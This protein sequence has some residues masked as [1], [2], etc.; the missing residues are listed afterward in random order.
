MAGHR[1]LRTP[2]TRAQQ[3]GK[4]LSNSAAMTV[5]L[6]AFSNA[7]LADSANPWADVT[8]VTG[9][10]S[11]DLSVANNNTIT[12]FTDRTVTTASSA[13]IL[14]N[15]SV[16]ILQNNSGS[17]FVLKT[18]GAD[19]DGAQ[20]QGSLKANG[21]VMVLDRNGVFFGTGSRIDVGGIVASTGD[22]DNDA[23]MRGDTTLELSNFGDASVIN[24]GHI[25]IH[26]N[27][28]AALVAPHVVNNGVIEA[29][30]G[31]VSLASGT[32]TATVDMYGDGMVQFAVGGTAGKALIENAGR[33]DGAT[34]QMTAQGAKGV[35]D[36]VI[37]MSGVINATSATVQG[38]KII[39]SGG[40]AGKVKVSGKM[41]ASGAAGGGSVKVT[42][43]T[44]EVT[45]TAE[46][47]ANALTSGNGGDIFF[48]AETDALYRGRFMARGGE[49]S[50]NGGF[51][52]LS[53]KDEVGFDGEV[54]TRAAFGNAGSFLIDP[55]FSIIHSG[56]LNNLLGFQLFLS[57]EAIA[58]SLFTNAT[59][60]IQADEYIDVGTNS[61]GWIPGVGTGDIDL[62]QHHDWKLVDTDPRWW[63]IN[64]QWVD[65]GGVTNGNLQ[66][67]SDTVN[68]N[69]NLKLGN[70]DLAV[71]ANTVN[72]NAKVSD[73]GGL[74]DQ[75]DITSTATT[76]NVLS[77][78]A[79]IQQGLYLAAAG[80]T[81]NVAAG[82]YNES[83]DVSKA[84]TL[85]GANAA[86]NPNT[87]VRG[88]ETII[89]GTSD[90]TLALLANNITVEG[91]TILGDANVGLVDYAI[92]AE[93]ANNASVQNNIVKDAG[94]GIFFY[95][96]NGAATD[97]LI[98]NNKVSDAD[99]QAIHIRDNAY[100][101]ILNNVIT[102]S[103][104]GITTENFSKA[105]PNGGT[106]TISGNSVSASKI[107]IRNNLSYGTQT[108]FTIANN[109]ITAENSAETRRWTGIDVISQQDG[110]ATIFKDNQIDASAVNATRQT[111][112]YELTN[113]TNANRAVI[114]GGSVKNA[115]VG[116]WAT[117]GS[118]YTG[119]VNDLLI[120]NVAFTNI[121]EAGI[122]V[123]DTEG[124]AG[125]NA[126][127]TKVT[128]GSGNTFTNTAYDLAIAGD[129]VTI[130]LD[131]GFDG[132]GTTLVKA[133]GPSHYQQGTLTTNNASIN[134]GIGATKATGTVTVEA[135]SFTE[136]VEIAK[137]LNLV[138]A[139]IG[140]TILNATGTMAQTG[141]SPNGAKNYAVLYVHD[142]ADVN[143]SGFT[144][145]GTANTETKFNDTNRFVGA[146]YANAGGTFANNRITG[147]DPD[148]NKRAAFGLLAFANAGP[149]RNLAITN[150]TVDGF[151]NFGIA[152]ANDKLNATLT[153]NTITGDKS[154]GQT[155]ILVTSGAKTT[156]GGV[157]AA[158]GNTINSVDKG[159]EVDGA[160]NNTFQNNT[161]NDVHNGFV[162]SNSI[163]TK[164]L[165]NTILGNSV[166][167]I[168]LTNSNGST[169]LG[170][171]LNSF[172]NGIVVDNSDNVTIDGVTLT[173]ISNT[174]I[175]VK[176]SDN[177]K[178]QKNTMTGGK[179]GVALNNVTNSTI[180]GA[181]A[182]F[183]NTIQNI[184]S[185]WNNSGINI[186]KGDNL[187][188]AHNVLNN[189]GGQGIYAQD[190]WNGSAKTLN[191]TNNQIT[192]AEHNAISIKQWN[193]AKVADN[194]IT[195]TTYGNGVQLEQT[196]GTT[197]TG[198]T[199]AD[200][201]SAAV[202]LNYGNDGVTIA[203]NTISNSKHGIRLE[204][205]GGQSNANT[206]IGSFTSDPAKTNTI[207]GG[208]I[209]ILVEGGS[210][211]WIQGNN[212]SGGSDAGIDVKNVGGS[213]A[214]VN[215]NVING[216]K[217]GIRVSG[218][219]ATIADNRIGLV[220]ALTGHGISV[221]DGESSLITVNRIN[222]VG[223]DAIRAI[224]SE[225]ISIAH[226]EIGLT[227]GANNIK[228]HGV[229]V[230]LSD[231][232]NV[233][234]NEISNV[235]ERGININKGANVTVDDN[236]LNKIGKEGIRTEQVQGLD[237]TN[238][239]LNSIGWNGVDVQGG[240]NVTLHKN[241][242]NKIGGRGLNVAGSQTAVTIT[243]NDV[244]GAGESGIVVTGAKNVKINNN[245]VNTIGTKNNADYSG[246]IAT[247]V[248]NGLTIADNDIGYTNRNGTVGAANNIKHTGITVKNTDDATVRNNNVVTAKN[249]IVTD[250][251]DRLV[252]KGNVLV[253]R[254][255]G[256]GTGISAGNSD[257]VKINNLNI[258]GGY[259]TGIAADTVTDLIIK[260]NA[261][262]GASTDGI[263]VRN[264][265]AA[266][267]IENAVGLGNGN[268][269]TA[270]NSDDA[271]IQL[272]V[273]GLLR[274]NGVIVSGSGNSVVDQNTIRNVSG[275]G[276]V[277]RPSHNGES[278]TF[279]DGT[280]VTQ[281]TLRD[282]GGDGVNS[283]DTYDLTIENNDIRRVDGTGI[284][285]N[286][287]NDTTIRGNT[288]RSF[289]GDGIAVT[290]E[291]GRVRILNND[292][293]N[294]NGEASDGINVSDSNVVVIRG[295]TIDNVSG[296]GIEAV[297]NNR[298]RIVRNEIGE[299]GFI[300][301]NGIVLNG[302]ER[303]RL[304]SNVISNAGANGLYA[305][306]EYNG[307]I[308]LVGNT[309][310][311]NP[312]GALFESGTID[313]T[314]E[315]ANTF[316]GGDVAMRFAPIGEPVN[317]NEEEENGGEEGGNEQLFF[318]KLMEEGRA[319][320]GLR[321]V[322][323][324]IGTTFFNGQ[325]TY[326]V[327]LLNGALFAPG[328]P[329]VLNGLNATYDGFRP[330][331]VGGILTQAQYDAIESKIYH[332]N[333]ESTLGLFYFGAVPA[334]LDDSDIYNNYGALSWA[335]GRF[336]MTILGL[337]SVPASGPAPSTG[338]GAGTQ[339]GF[340]GNVADF[341]ANLAPAAGGDDTGTKKT[342]KSSGIN[343]AGDLAA[344]EPAAGGNAE[345]EPACWSDA[346]ARASAGATVNYSFGGTSEETLNQAAACGGAI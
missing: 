212:V 265:D 194:T 82:T 221:T 50:G 306:G 155:G 344:L 209:G 195:G 116:V 28:L 282:I 14:S 295:N 153:K 87:G 266:K 162:V 215:H 273:I 31:K 256:T 219:T 123:E 143:V 311:N 252:V 33:I 228:G 204:T 182:S 283:Y 334:D 163:N 131:A 238:N 251:T 310:N 47:S 152:L 318:A 298:V 279:S 205:V 149:V 175:T 332:F 324:T 121:G 329:T 250:N 309:F 229:Y 72:L 94:F 102:G 235:K 200:A 342:K 15:Q 134:T 9:S 233:L 132:V 85:K 335:N 336:R 46:V 22:V 67:V 4:M 288:I 8:A 258:V 24:N 242:L 304:L 95:N 199:I 257:D 53:A 179:T 13:D 239:E 151:Q 109:T 34:V 272:N 23:V 243:K 11:V 7:A 328:T 20:I 59:V 138:G 54:D 96:T 223:G 319:P 77:N 301:G 275:T 101:D 308:A 226:N 56:S 107:G 230:S 267:I 57:A 158:D 314:S 320:T 211:L 128:I 316:N 270:E 10:I 248:T 313:L 98:K 62:S 331:T 246:I 41:D 25:S 326:Y 130:G 255:N 1:K 216:T 198:N 286:A 247:S 340:V 42:G 166:T 19:Q 307:R 343:V 271:I 38:G 323:D 66:L 339:P 222:N 191:I 68:F 139:G 171:S 203:G 245:L 148:N 69:K 90:Y 127:G 21:R 302:N 225:T 178:V 126:T 37:N 137:A 40:S 218:T 32:E 110:V 124:N 30:L 292:I 181:D 201:K 317:E 174:H 196:T 280:T 29:P 274:G 83:V 254:N 278:S 113:M 60:T 99:Q 260:N 88:A 236:I 164:L 18:T 145:D 207:T 268:G 36:T 76:V 79:L 120:K 71:N 170:G 70:G 227:G 48:M 208:E 93:N 287:A 224:S 104:V 299:N 176:D 183:A 293:R 240:S 296:D 86:V 165:N 65:F 49:V 234:S 43:E 64:L 241:T 294:G 337:P 249:G 277:I 297:D 45:D 150:N 44:I 263:I 300:T 237:I 341:L 35:V 261:V 3:I 146:L 338:T 321:L 159:V 75:S 189:V 285:V 103:A 325:T 262:L 315:N 172:I 157:N 27:G 58:K 6:F 55:R 52:E 190:A 12:Q 327:E 291:L 253:G 305:A 232:A 213:Y 197:V 115:D 290:D 147:I 141:T 192:A 187:T 100:A 97:S 167:G 81:V 17:L 112:G 312:V 202:D 80:A 259:D 16:N 125:V 114:D 106:T 142:A 193:G 144:I 117:D 73:V 303:V 78:N 244:V 169:V 180:G 129:G 160:G 122:L 92:F 39:L 345:E 111:A 51:V 74:L 185:G 140:Q 154:A 217:D 168:A 26:G 214:I 5:G 135:G 118:F 322:D 84:V 186:S 105:N 276:I 220:S 184:A 161:L 63:V 264:S 289:G 108:G 61:L 89:K 281:N 2:N 346:V 177:A 284:A 119:A 188:I 333:D 330:S 136:Q 173:N 91:F 206:M 231:G 210:N 156:V 269:I 133:A